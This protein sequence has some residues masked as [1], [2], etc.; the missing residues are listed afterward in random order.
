MK[1]TVKLVSL[2]AISAFAMVVFLFSGQ[3]AER[4][5]AIGSG[6]PAGFTSAPDE[7][8]CTACH[9]GATGN[10]TFVITPPPYYLPGRTYAVEV[11]HTASDLTRK[12]WGFQMTSLVNQTGQGTFASVNANTQTLSDSGRSYV[13]HTSVGT[14]TDQ[15]GGA[16]WNMNWTA[17]ATNV[18]T[19]TMYS[20]G[21]QANSD[22]TS[23]GDLIIESLARI[24]QYKAIMDLDGDQKT[25]LSVFRPNGASSEWWWN[26]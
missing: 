16:V 7:N 13:Q 25:D 5:S 18:G 11:R 21:N 1:Y 8:S 3:T 15:T 2:V 6:P 14:F 20:A 22:T 12:R 23:D 24:P 26:R 9:G 4:A 19:I 17:P 10:G